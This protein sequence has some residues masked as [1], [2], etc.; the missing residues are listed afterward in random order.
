M[1]LAQGKQPKCPQRHY[2]LCLQVTST[3]LRDPY[4]RLLVEYYEDP[5]LKDVYGEKP[6]ATQHMSAKDRNDYNQF[7][8]GKAD[9]KPMQGPMLTNPVNLNAFGTGPMQGPFVA[10]PM[11]QMG[12]MGPMGQ[13]G[14]MSRPPGNYPIPNSYYPPQL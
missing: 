13:M 12:Q 11:N 5:L 10:P 7:R 14:Q 4:N 9:K 8:K 1:Q 3:L 6:H 2:N